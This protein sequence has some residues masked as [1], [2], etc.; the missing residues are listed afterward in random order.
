[1]NSLTA[2]RWVQVEIPIPEQY[3]TKYNKQTKKITTE[4]VTHGM[5]ARLL[6][7]PA[8]LHHTG[9][10]R[11]RSMLRWLSQASACPGRT[12]ALGLLCLAGVDWCP[13]VF[14]SIVLFASFVSDKTVCKTLIAVAAATCVNT[15]GAF[16]PESEN[17]FALMMTE[18]ETDR[19]KAKGVE[20]K[21]D[22][23]NEA[24]KGRGQSH[25]DGKENV[26]KKADPTFG[27]WNDGL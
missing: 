21:L 9:V 10:D 23:V 15:A 17:R 6:S 4:N 8:P 19:S 7:C 13:A 16:G 20:E 26:R 27:G 12:A 24:D 1:M 22:K 14:R 5:C 18:E 11:L 2:C 3:I 25:A